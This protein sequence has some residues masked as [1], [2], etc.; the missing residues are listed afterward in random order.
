MKKFLFTIGMALFCGTTFA[1]NS[2]IFKAQALEQKG[3]IKGAAALL[4][5]ALKNPKTT[6][7][8]EMYHQ[9]AEDNA[10]L[11]NPELM[12]AA[13]GMPFDTTSFCS[14]LDKMVEF[15]TKSHEA[16]TKP[17]E[18]GRVKSKFVAQ[19]RQRMLTMVDYYNYA[20]MFQYQN[21]DTAKAIA[22]FEKY[23]DFPNNKIFT[24][25]ESDSIFSGKRT[26]YSQTALNLASLS[27][28]KKDWTNAIK[29]ADIALKDTI[30]TRDLYIIKMQAYA[31]KGDSAMWLKTMT[32]AVA[33]TENEGFMQNLLYYYVSHNDVKGAESM[34]DELATASPNSKMAWYMKGCVELN[35]KKNYVEARK[36][37]EHA[38][39]IDPD[40]IDANVNIAY[41]YV[42]QAVAD[43]MA[44]KYKFIGTNKLISK[45]Q[46]PAYKKE[47]ALVQSYYQKAQPYMEKVRSLAPSQPKLWVY[48]LQ[49]IYENL[50]MKA[51]KAEM[52]EIIKGL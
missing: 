8:A 49:M 10:K 44:G 50:Q 47:L 4:E 12:K 26:A 7:F 27:Y 42:N 40:Y 11:F 15:Y 3:D 36:C 13:Q 24:Q 39:S 48:T 5:E 22:Y 19:N 37:F 16:D 6:K 46:M 25:H 51:K 33:K 9:V 41:T 2:A 45:A 1:Q 29:Y 21:H 38:L 14:Y 43:K 35:L 32:E 18:K 17:D 31:A 23:L 52:D 34:A 28:N 30:G 20:A